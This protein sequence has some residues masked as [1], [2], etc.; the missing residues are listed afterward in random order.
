MSDKEEGRRDKQISE[1][2]EA[3]VQI[4]RQSGTRVTFGYLREKLQGQ[5]A[6]LGKKL[7]V[8]GIREALINHPDVWYIVSSAGRRFTIR[9]KN[10][11]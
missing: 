5:Y 4:L 6:A 7:K 1:A 3:A 9:G 8:N 2:V 10:D 11:S